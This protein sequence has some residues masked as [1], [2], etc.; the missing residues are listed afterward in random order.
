MRLCLSVA[1]V[2][3][4]ASA[5]SSSDDGRSDSAAASRAGGDAAQ[6]QGWRVGLRGIGPVEAGLPLAAVLPDTSKVPGCRIV[7]SGMVPG[8][9]SF[10][11]VDDVI[12]R[13]QVE[14][15]GAQTEEGVRIGDS[16]ARVKEVYAGRVTITPHKY[17]LGHYV[18]VA[19]A[20]AADSGFRLLFETDG[21][22]V[23]RYR[24]G[25]LPEVGWVEG[26]A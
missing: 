11:V 1:V 20:T 18:T 23:T 8:G 10:L 17:T 24:A 4:A 9:V 12:A 14:S 3:L 7:R 16:E 22:R 5:C 25:R 21:Q 13:V 2:L 26:C 6:A 19:P 15:G